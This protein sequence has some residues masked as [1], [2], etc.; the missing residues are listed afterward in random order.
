M[1]TF[2][3][4]DYQQ[5][6]TLDVYDSV[7]SGSAYV[8]GEVISRNP[9]TKEIDHCASASAAKTA[10]AAGDELYIIAQSDAVT[11]KTG[12]AYKTYKLARSLSIS[13][14]SSALSVIA[15]YRVDNVDNVNF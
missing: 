14:S 10:L 15:A 1:A 7:N 12:T 6:Y 2:K 13:D 3:R 9:N 4:V 5:V 8:V 11:N